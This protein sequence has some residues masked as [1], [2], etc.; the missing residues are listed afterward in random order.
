MWGFLSVFL[1]L[2]ELESLKK[3]HSR[4]H[5]DFNGFQYLHSLSSALHFGRSIQLFFANKTFNT[6][7]GTTISGCVLSIKNVLASVLSYSKAKLFIQKKCYLTYFTEKTAISRKI[8]KY[9]NSDLY[10]TIL[11]CHV[12]STFGEMQ[13]EMRR[14]KF[15]E[16]LCLGIFSP[17][18]VAC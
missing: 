8:L 17:F 1:F 12:G 4:Q 6:K 13:G 15:F 14:E 3:S 11:L 16:Y 7:I 10:L 9:S 2:Q 5:H 18:P